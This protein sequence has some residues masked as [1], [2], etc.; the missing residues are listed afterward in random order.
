LSTEGA[1]EI[2][3]GRWPVFAVPC[4]IC[5]RNKSA[6]EEEEFSGAFVFDH[7]AGELV[8]EESKK[9]SKFELPENGDVLATRMADD[10][11]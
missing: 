6:Q 9:V 8:V 2:Q 5:R 7:F 3:K 1:Q 10:E 4:R 11:I